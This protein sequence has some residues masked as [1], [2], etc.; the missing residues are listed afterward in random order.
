VAAHWI[1]NEEGE[2]IEAA[3]GQTPATLDEAISPE[4]VEEPVAAE[5][6]DLA[7]T[8]Q[9]KTVAEVA[10][11]HS[12]LE[13]VMA[14]QGN[15]LSALRQQVAQPVAQ[16]VP[17]EARKEVDYFTDPQGAVKATIDEHEVIQE[18]RQ[19][20]AQLKRDAGVQKLVAK[21]PDLSEIINSPE[22][23]EWSNATEVRKRLRYEADQMFSVE[24]ADELVSNFK[25]IKGMSAQTKAVGETARKNAVRSANTGSPSA[26]PDGTKSRKML[27][28]AEL[29]NR[30]NNDPQWYEANEAEIMRA[31]A[32]GRVRG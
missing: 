24:A 11:M 19:T 5:E 29:R 4:P 32:E 10:K 16:P 12:E 25:D 17:E 9:G 21:H 23:N 22:F 8:Y 3:E 15:E 1:E 13:K 7:P 18:F 20:T 6:P 26:N 30:F 14:R 27:N 28:G 31:Y 2:Q